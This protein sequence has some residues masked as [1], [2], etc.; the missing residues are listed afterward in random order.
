MELGAL[1]L[2]FAAG[3]VSILSPCV[4]PLLPVVLAAAASQHRFGPAALAGGLSLSFLVAGTFV[5]TVGF[6]LGLDP[7]A[8]RTA[9]A[10]LLVMAGA[11]LLVPLLQTKAAVLAAPFGNWAHTR[12]GGRMPAGL[13]G[14]FCVG[15]L[16]GAVWTPCVGP[17]LGAASVLAAQG[18]DLHRVVL[19]MLLFAI[20]TALPMLMLGALSREALVRWRGQ[21]L[22]AGRTGKTVLGVSLVGTGA[23]ILVG[24]DRTIEAA[25]LARLPAWLTEFAASF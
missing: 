10:A 17:T 19:T 11:V 23:L 15:A 22:S 24:Y 16:L 14:Q 21:M 2:A 8:F 7:D 18:R 3:L 25:L 12:F 20:G 4:L 6:S 9:A 13:A 5:A 1:G